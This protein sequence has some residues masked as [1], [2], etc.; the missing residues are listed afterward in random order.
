VKHT[1]R[2][3]VPVLVK[4]PSMV[5]FRCG[6]TSDISNLERIECFPGHVFELNNQAKHAVSNCDSDHRVHLILDYFDDDCAES[7]RSSVFSAATTERIKLQPGETLLQTRRSVD[8][9]FDRGR[10]P[11]PTFLILGA[12]KAGTTSLYEYMN[13]HP[14]VAKAR[15]RETHCLDW[16]WNGALKTVEK[17]RR[18][19]HSFYWK[20]ELEFHPS[21]LT[22]DSTPSYLLDSRNV[23]PRLKRVFDW[24]VKFFVMLRDPVKRAES[25]FAMA[26]SKEG[27]EAQ[28]KCRGTEWRGKSINEV[29]AE[30]LRNMKASGLIPYFDIQTG[31]VD[32]EAFNLFSGS[33]QEDEAWDR[34]L[35]GIPMNTGSHCL[36]GRGL[37]ELNL[38]PWLAAFDRRDFLVMK[39]ERLHEPGGVDC[40]MGKVWAHL[41]VPAFQIVDDS[42]KNQRKYDAL[43]DDEMTAYLRRFFEPHNKRLAAVLGEEWR[44][45]WK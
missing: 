5:V 10:R 20:D 11:T 34:Y 24:R 4:D 23:I 7:S 18:W 13:Q 30:D 3:H 9:L 1:H 16:R 6:L 29:V 28:L 22:G 31:C 37:Y 32:R 27:T 35:L 44:D 38:R 15:R 12:Q 40:E 8:R 25:H 33:S 43:L 42:P 2:V 26:T 14:L 17:Q 19:C 41:E 21:C 45:A 36:L 39:L